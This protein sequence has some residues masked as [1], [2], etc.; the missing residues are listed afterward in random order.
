MTAASKPQ[1]GPPEQSGSREDPRGIWKGY[2]DENRPLTAY[3]QL[4][5]LYNLALVLFLIAARNAGR[6]LPK[7]VRVGD[8]L[9]LGL[10]TFKLS[11]LLAK[12]MVTSPLRAPFTR[13]VGPAGEGE[14]NEEPRG[15]GMQRALGEL[16]TC[17]FCLGAWVAAFLAYGLVL[18]PPLTRFLA[19]IL[20]TYAVADFF[21]LAYGAAAEAVGKKEPQEQ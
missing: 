2:S 16:L 6:P 12:D 14:V 17:P 15:E 11:R 9:L 10:A 13:F 18:S 3:A 21:Q 4:V 5:G 7:R 1:A 19:G 8:I 20:A